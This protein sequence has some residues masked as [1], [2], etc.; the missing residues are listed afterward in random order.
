MKAPKWTDDQIRHDLL[1]ALAQLGAEAMPSARQLRGAG[2]GR[3]VSAVN[4]AGGLEVWA[5][6]LGVPF[7]PRVAG[8]ARGKP[9]I[10]S[11]PVT[12][13][14]TVRLTAPQTEALDRL[15][16]RWSTS[17]AEAVRRSL[18]IAAQEEA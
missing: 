14:L 13:I 12:R 4:R 8:W 9:R 1:V 17:E 10:A 16:V 3:L 2:L 5:G 11:G 15:V 7:A 18:E 6:R